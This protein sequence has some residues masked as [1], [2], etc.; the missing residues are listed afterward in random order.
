MN[1]GEKDLCDLPR[2]TAEFDGWHIDRE[3]TWFKPYPLGIVISLFRVV[4][5]YS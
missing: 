4:H 2:G 5:G 1:K 3:P